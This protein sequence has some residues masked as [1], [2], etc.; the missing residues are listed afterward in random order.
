MTAAV[1][2]AAATEAA[3]IV[4]FVIVVAAMTI[5]KPVSLARSTRD[6]KPVTGTALESKPLQIS[7]GSESAPILGAVSQS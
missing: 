6:R 7:E 4:A 2:T 1:A 5:S 3:V